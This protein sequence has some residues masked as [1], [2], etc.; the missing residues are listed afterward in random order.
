MA[1]VKRESGQTLVALLFFVLVGLIITV[2]A[3]I[4]MATNSI[5]A[6]KLSQG[7]ITRQLAESG[8]ENALIQLLR[9][10]NYTGET[11]ISG[12]DTILVTVTGSI[13]K[14][15]DS[16]ATSGD[17]VR[18]IEVQADYDGVLIPGTWREIN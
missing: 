10:K 2:A 17:F 13:T 8:V 18:R 14:T 3:T 7:E 16:T 11:L 4:I 6:Q 12:N 9:D 1:Y 5:T 15:I